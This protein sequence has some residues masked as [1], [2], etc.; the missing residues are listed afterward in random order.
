MIAN[1]L[2]ALPEIIEESGGGFVY[3]SEDELLSA[4]RKLADDAGLRSELGENG[5]RAYVK[6]WNEEPHMQQY[7]ALIESLMVQKKSASET[8]QKLAAP[9]TA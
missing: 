8:C 9:A 7:F 2:G 4:I 3:R 6:C 1:D 5:Y